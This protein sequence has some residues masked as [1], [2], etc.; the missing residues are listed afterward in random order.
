MTFCHMPVLAAKSQ[1][2]ILKGNRQKCTQ[3][4]AKI[5]LCIYVHMYMQKCLLQKCL[6]ISQN[7]LFF[8]TFNISSLT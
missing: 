7:Y 8:N 1:L 2:K 6:S 5:S 4:E 3:R